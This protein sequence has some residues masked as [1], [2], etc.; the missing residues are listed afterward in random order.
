MPLDTRYEPDPFITTQEQ[1]RIATSEP[2]DVVAMIAEI[3]QRVLLKIIGHAVTYAGEK[4]KAIFADDIP[5]PKA[6]V[7]GKFK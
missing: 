1:E 5:K 7:L 3:E 6:P 2:G 4:G